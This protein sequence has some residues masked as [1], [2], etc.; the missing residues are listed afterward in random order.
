ML[1]RVRLEVSIW[2]AVTVLVDVIAIGHAILRARGVAGTL[3]WVFA[4]LAFPGLGAVAY[5]ALS[6]P[7][8]EPQARRKRLTRAAVRQALLQHVPESPSETARLS[9]MERSLLHLC[10]TLTGHPPSAGNEV[11]LLSDSEQA[12]EVIEQAIS[13]AKKHVW[14]EYYIIANDETGRR[15]L[16]LLAERARAGVEVRLLYDAVGSLGI[17]GKRLQALREAGGKVEAFLPLNPLRRRWSVHLRNHRKMIVVDGEVG[18][19]GGMN[20]GDQYSG[21]ARRRGHAHFH[22]AHLRLRGPEVEDLGQIFAE[23]WYFATDEQL[24]P[25]PAPEPIP[26]ASPIVAIVPSGPDQERNANGLAYF[27]G[28]AASE[29]RLYLTSPYFIPDEPTVTALI[30]AALRGVDVRILLP[31]INDVALVAPAARSYY[32]EL[33]EGG[34][35]IFE[36]QPSMLHAKT[37]VVDGS[38]SIVGS[39]NVDIRSFRLNFELGALVFDAAFAAKLEERFMRD[40]ADSREI[41]LERMAARGFFTRL[42]HGVARLLSPLL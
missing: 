14:A 24:T 34:V 22:D 3:A 33:L 20:V 6:S 21:K 26:G 36:F 19:T 23:D 42:G 4:I 12:F 32:E 28:I 35:R 30:A 37:M 15:F 8:I 18:F 10:V 17:D 16:D 2:V 38:F 1:R 41:T 7:R 25:P 29:R 40:L 5:A 31:G 13:S 9:A 39:A 11:E 27:S